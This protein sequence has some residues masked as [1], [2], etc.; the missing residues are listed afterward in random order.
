MNHSST[1]HGEPTAS[2]VDW[3][4]GLRFDHVMPAHTNGR[5]YAQTER[6][7]PQRVFH[8]YFFVTEGGGIYPHCRGMRTDAARAELERVRDDVLIRTDPN[9]ADHFL[10]A[11]V[12]LRHQIQEGRCCPCILPD[13]DR[14]LVEVVS[15][16]PTEFTITWMLR[17]PGIHSLGNVL[18]NVPGLREAL[19]RDKEVVVEP[20]DSVNPRALAELFV[21]LIRELAKAGERGLLFQ[22]LEA[23]HVPAFPELFLNSFRRFKH[24]LAQSVLKEWEAQ[25]SS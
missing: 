24:P 10:T 4:G 22:I 13:L 20:L 21:E 16:L 17:H 23:W 2:I 9:E 5:R 6:L 3:P 15:D 1:R 19:V 18:F 11:A 12:R 8:L 14:L 25:Q 7:H